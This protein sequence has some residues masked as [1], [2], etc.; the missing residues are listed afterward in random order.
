MVEILALLFLAGTNIALLL[1]LLWEKYW[2]SKERSKLVNAVLAKNMSE[3]HTAEMI[4]NTP[5]KPLVAVGNPDLIAEDE[6]SDEE[7]EKNV[8]NQV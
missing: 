3:F 6:L 5:S 8:L 4:D 1:A 7:F 2:N